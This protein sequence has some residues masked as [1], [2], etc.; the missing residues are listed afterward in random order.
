MLLVRDQDCIQQTTMFSHKLLANIIPFPC[1]VQGHRSHIT[2]EFNVPEE[3]ES[4]FNW[5]NF[6]FKK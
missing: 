4:A 1:R 5:I 6:N 2:I 3:M